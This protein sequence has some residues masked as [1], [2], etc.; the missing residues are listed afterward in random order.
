MARKLLM[1]A[2]LPLI[3]AD[4]NS[5]IMASTLLVFGYVL[6]ITSTRPYLHDAC[7]TLALNT[8]LSLFGMLFCGL[9]QN[10]ANM[11]E[12]ATADT[13]AS[14]H[15]NAD[16]RALDWQ[17]LMFVC[18]LFG[19]LSVAWA[20]LLQHPV[21]ALEA[22][23]V[24]HRKNHG[25]QISKLEWLRQWWHGLHILKAHEKRQQREAEVSEIE[26]RATKA[27]DMKREQRR[28]HGEEVRQKKHAEEGAEAEEEEA[29]QPLPSAA[30]AGSS[31]VKQ[32]PT[33]V[34]PV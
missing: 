24:A 25:E 11:Q 32:K 6:L 10:L 34:T 23:V 16:I 7:D 12:T 33:K 14:Q 4:T 19:W 28:Q 1:T 22:R 21:H 27:Q 5:Q 15:R 29:Q 17:W 18:S 3:F 2:I 30:S 13:A 8:Q 26:T 20:I 31:R 9:C